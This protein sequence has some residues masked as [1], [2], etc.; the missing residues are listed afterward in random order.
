M[1]LIYRRDRNDPSF[2]KTIKRKRGS[3][4]A[5]AH[6]VYNSLVQCNIVVTTN[7]LFL[8]KWPFKVSSGCEIMEFQQKLKLITRILKQTVGLQHICR[9][10]CILNVIGKQ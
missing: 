6:A 10:D 2:G 9:E 3:M 8:R 7:F 1:F 5:S 4:P